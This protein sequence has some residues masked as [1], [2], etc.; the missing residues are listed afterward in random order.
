[1]IIIIIIIIIITIFTPTSSGTPLSEYFLPIYQNYTT[2]THSISYRSMK[3]HYNAREFC[4]GTSIFDHIRPTSKNQSIGA[5]QKHRRHTSWSP[6]LLK[7]CGSGQQALGDQDLEFYSATSK[8]TTHMITHGP[9]TPF[10]TT[11]TDVCMIWSVMMP[12]IYWEAQFSSWKDFPG[13]TMCPE[14]FTVLLFTGECNDLLYC[15]PVVSVTKKN[16]NVNTRPPA[17][18]IWHSISLWMTLQRS[19]S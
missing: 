17:T 1:M 7:S 18:H 13:Q 2:Q 16:A 4:F 8:T 9:P 15:Y 11:P 5:N 3:V 12:T 10:K 19:L 6:V 14:W